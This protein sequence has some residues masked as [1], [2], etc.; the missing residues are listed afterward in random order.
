MCTLLVKA[1]LDVDRDPIGR[2]IP[3]ATDASL[4]KIE[5]AG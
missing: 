5:V 3:D 1:S 4:L 2:L